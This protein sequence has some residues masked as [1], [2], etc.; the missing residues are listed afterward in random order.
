MILCIF[1]LNGHLVVFFLFLFWRFA[2]LLLSRSGFMLYASCMAWEPRCPVSLL[3][4]FSSS[5]PPLLSSPLQLGKWERERGIEVRNHSVILVKELGKRRKRTEHWSE[6]C[7][8][9]V[10]WVIHL[11]GCSGVVRKLSANTVWVS[12]GS[13]EVGGWNI[14]SH[15]GHGQRWLWDWGWMVCFS[16][17]I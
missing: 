14:G 11:N 7:R 4:S 2:F 3:M 17:F 15:F 16:V 1:T 12:K 8:T 9:D 6:D 13:G 10:G 5:S